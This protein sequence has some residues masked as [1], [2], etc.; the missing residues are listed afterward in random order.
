MPPPIRRL[1]LALSRGVRAGGRLQGTVVK[2]PALGAARTPSDRRAPRTVVWCGWASKRPGKA[3]IR[4]ESSPNQRSGGRLVR[5]S[6]HP[7]PLRAV[8]GVVAADALTS[9]MSLHIIAV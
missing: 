3:A 2:V 6:H 8:W 5:L 1:W 9:L 7:P 4:A